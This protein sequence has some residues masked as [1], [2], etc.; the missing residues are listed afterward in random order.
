MNPMYGILIIICIIAILVLVCNLA[1]V[2][3]TKN[4]VLKIVC[5]ILFAFSMMR[6][7]TLIIYGNSPSANQLETLRYFYLATSIGLAI[8]TASAI[9]HIT[10]MYREKISYPKYL[11]FFAPWIIFYSYVLICQ[12]TKIGIASTYGYVLELT[13]KFPVYLSIV[14]GSF[15]IIMILLC[16]IGILKYKHEQLR[17]QYFVIIMAQILLVLDGILYHMPMLQTLPKFTISE[18]LGFLAI[19]YAF[20]KKTI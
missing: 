3:Q 8:P 6:Y 18:I 7:L 5:A 12:P 16:L 2:I 9:W 10:P 4:K 13:G 15:A 14:Q 19:F 17:S 20:K 1:A 11:L